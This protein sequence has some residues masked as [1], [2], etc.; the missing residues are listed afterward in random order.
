MPTALFFAAFDRPD[1]SSRFRGIE[2][3]SEQSRCVSGI[4]R[5]DGLERTPL[6]LTTLLAA[7]WRN[8]ALHQRLR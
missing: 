3:A 8:G 1:D 2:I 5:V 7:D 4:F 6:L